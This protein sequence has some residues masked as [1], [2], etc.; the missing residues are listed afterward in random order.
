MTDNQTPSNNVP[1]QFMNEVV[2]ELLANNKAPWQKPWRA[3]VWAPYNPVSGAIYRGLNRI[4]LAG[5]DFEDPRWMTFNQAKSVGLFVKKYSKGKTIEFWQATEERR[6]LDSKG[7]PVILPNGR[8][9]TIAI[10]L[11]RPLLRYYK[12]FNAEQISTEDGQPLPAPTPRE[13][14]WEAHARSEE[15]II[16]SQIPVKH[17]Q[18]NRAFFDPKDMAVHMPPRESFADQDDYYA[19]ILHELGHWH[20]YAPNR[21]KS[22]YGDLKY[23][24]EEIR[25]EMASWMICQDLGLVKRPKNHATYVAEWINVMN[26]DQH[27]LARAALEAE[28]I[29]S[30]F[31]NLAPYESPKPPPIFPDQADSG[32]KSK[33]APL[34]GENEYPSPPLDLPPNYDLAQEI[35]PRVIAL[36]RLTQRLLSPGLVRG[37]VERWEAFQERLEEIGSRVWSWDWDYKAFLYEA[38]RVAKIQLKEARLALTKPVSNARREIT[39]YNGV[40]SVIQAARSLELPGFWL[41]AP[42][43]NPEAPPV[44]ASVKSVVGTL[45][46]DQPVRVVVMN[47]VEKFFTEAPPEKASRHIV[48]GQEDNLLA[49]FSDLEHAKDFVRVFNSSEPALLKDQEVAEKTLHW[50]N[51]LII[52]KTPE[53]EPGISDEKREEWLARL[54][55]KRESFKSTP[56][57]ILPDGFSWTIPETRPESQKGT[58]PYPEASYQDS[59]TS[60]SASRGGERRIWPPPPPPTPIPWDVPNPPENLP[61][62]LPNQ[63]PNHIEEPQPWTSPPKTLKPQPF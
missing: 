21:P 9:K 22:V 49:I 45:S 38:N 6:V 1:R 61:N 28:R 32:Y 52:A 5:T 14:P 41:N 34:F 15:I 62:N 24:Q 27:E 60:P 31:L 18:K 57:S 40:L 19:T 53:P 2:K 50:K 16:A 33:Y 25:V 46:N 48:L 42:A 59:P 8:P 35:K 30:H 51:R 55:K 26:S 23:G 54:R 36:N 11:P 17:D 10:L 13:L 58:S 39:V 29:K 7:E 37:S 20:K 12:V 43:Q 4:I 56:G 47:Q 63:L 44:L 3:D